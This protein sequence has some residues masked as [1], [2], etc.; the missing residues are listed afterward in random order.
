MNVNRIEIEALVV[1]MT[2]EEALDLEVVDLIGGMTEEE[3]IASWIEEIEDMEVHQDS[4]IEE[5]KLRFISDHL[6]AY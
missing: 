2:E 5:G 4:M 6:F 3:E 1:E